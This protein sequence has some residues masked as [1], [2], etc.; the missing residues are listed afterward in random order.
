[1]AP[2]LLAMPQ[3]STATTYAAP[4]VWWFV[5][6]FTWVPGLLSRPPDIFAGREDVCRL[7]WAPAGRDREPLRGDDNMA[8]DRLLTLLGET[9]AGT[10]DVE[11]ATSL[12]GRGCQ[13]RRKGVN[14]EFQWFPK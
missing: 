14:P 9:L 10:R 11:A 5:E 7:T 6:N 2:L 12:L 1:M 4:R 13:S 3:V 8:I